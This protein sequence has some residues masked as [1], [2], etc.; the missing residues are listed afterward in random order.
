MKNMNAASMEKQ[1]VA[2]GSH[3]GPIALELAAGAAAG[4]LTGVIAG[5]P[6]AV[7]G[8]V[9]GGA[10]GV[11]AGVLRHQEVRAERAHEEELDRDIGVFGGHIGEAPLN[12]PPP[13]HGLYHADVLGISSP[14]VEPS[15]G[16]IQNLG[17]MEWH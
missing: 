1:L 5:P 14:S 17:A 13:R 10:V 7:I 9:L 16:M 12:Q 11:A 15:E 6:G 2:G 3:A 8:A 4:A